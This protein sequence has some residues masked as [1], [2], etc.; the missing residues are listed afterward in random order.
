[1]VFLFGADE[2]LLYSHPYNYFHGAIDILERPDPLH[3]VLTSDNWH[4]WLGPWTIAPLYYLFVALLMAVFGWHLLAIQ[5]VQIA[6]DALCAVLTGRLGRRVAGE[7]G[8]WA[9]IAYALNFH[10]IEQA[11]ITL[12]E[13]LHTVLLA[14]LSAINN[15]P[16]LALAAARAALEDL[17][18]AHVR[19]ELAAQD[20]VGPSIDV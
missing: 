7:R 20:Q 6:L 14:H 1:M 10:A 9:G 17:G 3:Y 4:R 12:T 18:L 8:W 19:V 15:R 2:P 13:N 5:I 11:P 16:L